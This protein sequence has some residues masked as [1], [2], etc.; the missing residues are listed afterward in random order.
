MN[1]YPSKSIFSYI[2]NI[3]SHQPK[4]KKK[5]VKELFK[6]GFIQI[7]AA[8]LKIEVMKYTQLEQLKNNHNKTHSHC[9]KRNHKDL[10]HIYMRPEVNSNQFEI[11]NRCEML[12]HLNGNLHEDFT[13]ATF[14]AIAQT[15]LYM[16]KWYLLI[17]ANLINA[18]KCY[19]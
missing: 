9:I 2:L 6:R 5:A 13:A 17:N 3:T 15:L 4:K 11:S 18:K 10:E 1:K 8:N 14:Q 19:Q 12:F 16:I 7:K